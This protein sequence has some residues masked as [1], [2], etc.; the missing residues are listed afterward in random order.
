MTN[1]ASTSTINIVPVQG[2][3]GPQPTFTLVS[4]IGPAGTPFYP[5]IDPAQSGLSIT[6]STINS[7]VIGGISPSTGTFTNISTTT[8]TISTTPSGSTDL[9]NKAYVDMF[10]QG[11]VIKAEAQCAT[12]VNI[13]L[14]G[15]QTIDG[16][17]T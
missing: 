9:V 1:A 2:I 8:G 11:Y 14:S 3:F 10:T 12:T 15:L 16:Y 4:L 7:S 6:N 13:T 5:N 17:T